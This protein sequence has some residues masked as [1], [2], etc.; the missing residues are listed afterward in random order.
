MAM[1]Q[2][3]RSRPVLLVALVMA[4]LPGVSCSDRTQTGQEPVPRILWYDKPAGDWESEA[5]PLGNGRLG[6]MVFGGVPQERIQFNEDS[7]WIGDEKNTGAYQA[8]GDLFIETDHR[9]PV[10]Y[11]RQ[12]DIRRAV[13]TTTYQS[14]GVR[15]TR[16][17]FASYPAQV[18]VFR[19]T[20]DSPGA[21]S[22]TIRLVDAHE[23]RVV[24]KDDRII[25]SGSLAGNSFRDQDT[26][27]LHL[28]YEAQIQVLHAGGSLAAADTSITFRNCDS[29]TILLAADTS[30][31]NRHEEGWTGKH[32]TGRINARLAAAAARTFADLKR[33]HI[34]DY[35]ELFNRLTMDL[36]RTSAATRR[37]P[38]DRRLDAYRKKQPDPDLEELMFQYARYLMISSSRPGTLPANL[39]GLWNQRND[40]P[41]RSDYHTDV[42]IEMNYWFVDPANLPECFLPLAEWV[43][44]IREVRKAETRAVFGTR[45][46]TTRVENGIFGGSTWEWSQGDAAWLAQNL[47]DHFAFTRDEEYLRT[48][49]YPVMKE[50]CEFWADRLKELPNGTLVAPEGFSPEHG[51]REDGVSYDQQLVWDLFTNFDE[52]TREL[53]TDRDFSRTIAGLKSRLLEPRIGRWGQL[54]EWMVDRDDPA[55]H[56]RHLSHLVALHPGRQISPVTTPDL[57]EAARVSLDARGDEGTG[58]SKAWKICL[59]ARLLDGDHAFTLLTGMIRD[60]ILDNLLD[61]HPPFQIDGNFGYAAGICEMLLQSHLGRIHLLPALPGNWPAGEVSGLRARGGFKVDIE[62][63]NGKLSRA[64]I[65]SDKGNACL[66]QTNLPVTVT[67]GGREVRTTR[68]AADVTGF[69]TEEGRTYLIIPD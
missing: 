34:R 22:G 69:P 10:D 35:Q 63:R 14:G 12:L 56:H 51:P 55:D 9:D 64:V 32:P 21:C 39:Q 45:G 31:L 40:P 13:H 43:D 1:N 33:E 23:G 38:T 62:W 4:L 24:G 68:P 3:I 60:N 17:Y 48:R 57:A 15:Y 66:L 6:A 7:L 16:E 42:N 2:K 18:L 27:G 67:S 49:A 29:L 59:R 8:F 47:W 65:R 30:Y 58:W 25:M 52:A 46:W 36:G 28:D 61:T 44:S 53:G 54:Q 37:L 5:L 50:L 20:A 19:F 41:W 26:Y 11:R